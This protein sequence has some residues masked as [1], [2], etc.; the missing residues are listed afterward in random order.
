MLIMIFFKTNMW[1]LEKCEF[2]KCEFSS[3]FSKMWTK[4]VGIPTY[5]AGNWIKF[6]HV[7]RHRPN[8]ILR[9]LKVKALLSWGKVIFGNS[10]PCSQSQS[11]V[12]LAPHNPNR[13]NLNSSGTM[14]SGTSK[15]LRTS[16][17]KEVT[18]ETIFL[19]P[20]KRLFWGKAADSEPKRS[21]QNN[22]T[23]LILKPL[24]SF[25]WLFSFIEC[26]SSFLP[27]I[28]YIYVTTI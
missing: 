14:E 1:I 9:S 16:V 27:T 2:K 21:Q 25:Y 20:S 26:P 19:K 4:Q 17:L 10:A 12:G 28:C 13:M 18:P 23:N 7:G 3:N 11:K 22:W 8:K 24:K 6:T 15:S 5:L